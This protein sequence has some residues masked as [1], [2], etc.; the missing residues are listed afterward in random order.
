MFN[1]EK[2]TERE[3]QERAIKDMNKSFQLAQKALDEVIEEVRTHEKLRF[4][5]LHELVIKAGTIFDDM[6]DLDVNEFAKSA[7]DSYVSTLSACF[8]RERTSAEVLES[9]YANKRRLEHNW[10]SEIEDYDYLPKPRYKLPKSEVHNGFYSSYR[11][12]EF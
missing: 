8:S 11:P 4:D 5:T 6:P 12:R 2:L 3:V 1:V 7:I 10:G 9:L